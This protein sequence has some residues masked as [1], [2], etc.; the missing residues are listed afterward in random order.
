MK[1]IVVSGINL[2]EGGPLAI[3]E[4]FL[5]AVVEYCDLRTYH[6]IAFV[7]KKELFR[8]FSNKIEIIELPNSRK[9]YFTRLWYEYIYFY[10]Y[11]RKR[12]IS[13]W[14]SMHDITPTV[15]A[16]RRYTYCHNP[17]PFLKFEAKNLKFGIKQILVQHF[18]RYIYRINISK[19][20]AVIVQQDWMREE[21]KKMFPIRKV[22]VA[23]PAIQN[24]K[25]LL[26][27]RT[28][29]IFT[30]IYVAFPRFFK[31]FEVICEAA[32]LLRKKTEIPFQILLT[33]NGTENEYAKW[34]YQ[35]YQNIK[36]IKWIG[37]KTREEIFA[38]YEES[39][40]MIF[41]SK[42]ETWGV[43]ITEFK[44][45]EKT[46]LAADLMYAYETVGNYRKVNF[47]HPDDKR[48]LAAFMRNELYGRNSYMGNQL[49]QIAQPYAMDWRQLLR[50]LRLC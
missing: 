10:L 36:E 38:L 3:Y 29:S 8:R 6:I 13:I 7:H 50:L 28:H 20:N 25:A 4:D 42:M 11:S 45:T 16:E 35:K 32:K 15:R 37:R 31:N 23:R 40:C 12:Q 19:N 34:V 21:F 2:F 26:E 18:Y 30:F 33:L 39:D 41:P 5:D 9:S 22:I 17:S 49:K 1:T 27:N 46:I 24:T 14:I 44:L 47:F 43:P 48:K